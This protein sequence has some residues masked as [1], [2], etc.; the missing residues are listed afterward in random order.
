[1]MPAG[2]LMLQQNDFPSN[3]IGSFQQLR[4]GKELLD[5][6]LACEDETVDAHKVVLS[7][8]SPS[9]RHILSKVKQTHPLIY[10]K[11]ILL[12]D[13]VSLL[14]YIYTGETK[15]PAEDLNRFIEAA[16]EL[17]ITGL[18]EESMAG[19]TLNLEKKEKGEEKYVDKKEGNDE[20]HIDDSLNTSQ[21]ISEVSVKLQTTADLVE[22]FGE[23][24]LSMWKCKLCGKLYKN[25]NKMNNHMY[26]V[27]TED[28]EIPNKEETLEIDLD[29]LKTDVVEFDAKNL[30]DMDSHKRWRREI[31]KRLMEIIDPEQGK[32]WKCTVCD[33][34]R[35][36]KF[37]TESHIES[38]VKQLKLLVWKCTF[39]GKTCKT[40]DAL[41]SH[42]N[43]KHKE[44]KVIE[45]L[46]QK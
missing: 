9:F 45:D 16:E 10:L 40:R 32:M 22:Q 3:Y 27:H 19:H 41:K 6:T 39:C 33:V 35:K 17:K 26:S 29:Q 38:H 44:E 28:S 43:K 1:M 2:L 46:L 15:V 30:Y 25:A 5:V 18:A 34:I 36:S 4:V 37:K 14:D 12:K 7:A 13:L 21:D 31:S 23:G 24:G 42:N 8:C 20:I 11:G